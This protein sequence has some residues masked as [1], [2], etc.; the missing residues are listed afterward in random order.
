MTTSEWVTQT[1]SFVTAF[2]CH[3]KIEDIDIFPRA[4]NKFLVSNYCRVKLKIERTPAN[5]QLFLKEDRHQ[6]PELSVHYLFYF[7]LNHRKCI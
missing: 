5:F 3:N 7:C 6:F 2:K 4:Y 1:Y